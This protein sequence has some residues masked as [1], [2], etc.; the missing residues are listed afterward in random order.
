MLVVTMVGGLFLAFALSGPGGDLSGTWVA[1]PLQLF[2]LFLLAALTIRLLRGR[3]YAPSD[4]GLVVPQRAPHWAYAVLVAAAFAGLSNLGV[5]FIPQLR[6]AT[7]RSL[8]L[9][10]FG[11]SLA[12][13]IGFVLALTVAAPLGEELLYRGVIF[14]GVHDGIARRRPQSRRLAFWVAAIVSAVLFGIS[15]AGEGQELQLPFLILFGLGAAWLYWWTGSLF[16]PVLAHSIANGVTA[17]HAVSGDRSF[18]SPL[19]GVV[20]VLGPVLALGILW[21]VGRLLGGRRSGAR[22]AG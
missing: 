22:R 15:H 8:E 13:D 7:E 14:R 18:S 21:L 3:A 20:V 4:L 12:Q 1:T 19:V 17:F 9:M 16:A 10:P 11:V 5:Q 2:V 6:E